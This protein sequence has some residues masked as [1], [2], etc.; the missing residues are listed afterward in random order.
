THGFG[1]FYLSDQVALGVAIAHLGQIEEAIR[2]LEPAFA[3][4]AT[5]GCK[6]LVCFGLGEL[7]SFYAV[8][9]RLDVARTTIDAAIHQAIN[10]G[11]RAYL[12]FLH[13]IRADILAKA[14]KPDWDQVERELSHAISVAQSQ[15]AAT[16]EEEA[17]ARWNEILPNRAMANG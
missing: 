2:I 17:R 16:L 7:A 1:L 14:P 9:D 11:D 12:S 4:L 5:I 8:A 10:I 13:R 6:Y 15:G 3:G